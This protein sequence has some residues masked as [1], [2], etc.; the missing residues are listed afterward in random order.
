LI[1]TSALLHLWQSTHPLLPSI[2]IYTYI[3]DEAEDVQNFLDL[4]VSSTEMKAS[5]LPTLPSLSQI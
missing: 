4:F 2:P 5:F 1:K 3:I